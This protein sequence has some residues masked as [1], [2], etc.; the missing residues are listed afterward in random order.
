MFIACYQLRHFRYAGYA[1]SPR[2]IFVSAADG[3]LSPSPSPF[4][5]YFLPLSARVDFSV[6]SMLSFHAM[7]LTAT[8]SPLELLLFDS[9]VFHKK[10]RQSSTLF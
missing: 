7:P 10:A 6:L 4:A 9:Y 1:T 2:L 5:A 3:L 8:T